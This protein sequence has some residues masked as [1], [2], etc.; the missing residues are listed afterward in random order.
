[1]STIPQVEQVRRTLTLANGAIKYE[2]TTRITDAGDLP[3]KDLFVLK[4]NDPGDAKD[5]VLARVATPFDVRQTDS[6][7]P[8]YIK[9]STADLI[10]IAPDV[11]ARIANVDEITGLPRDRTVAV[12]NGRSEYL[13]SVMTVEYDTLTTASA[14]YKQILARL[15]SLVEEW[16]SLFTPFA[17]NPSQ[18]Y[19]LPAP[20]SSLEAERTASFT[21]ARDAR[22]SAE[23]A[24]DAAQQALDACERD[25]TADKAIYDFLVTDVAFLE[26][27]RAAVVG[28]TESSIPPGTPVTSQV[29]DFVL[30][31]GAFTNDERSYQILLMYKTM[32]RAEYAA[33][34]SECATRCQQLRA[35]LLQAQ[36]GVD[37]ARDAERAALAGVYEICPTF[38]PSTV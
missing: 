29:R 23:A 16:R 4:I 6:A 38:D 7:S 2:I 15:S 19:E 24:R 12:R 25:C 26:A 5:D 30:Q 14:A 11:F 18:S 32:Q 31:L 20:G 3:F 9:V 27:A 34:V 1:M 22:T 37:A 17:T 35:T 13:T 36:A 10:T 21:A 33:K 8:K 28:M